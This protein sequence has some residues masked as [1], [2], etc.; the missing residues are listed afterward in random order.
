V[1]RNPQH[2]IRVAA[3][4]PDPHSYEIIVRA[5]VFDE[6]PS[7]VTAAA[8]AA[9]YAVIVPDD[10][11]ASYGRRVSAGLKAANVEVA[12][13]EF[14]AGEASKT[15][16]TWAELTD[17]L[18][19]LRYGRDSCIIAVGGGV[20]GDL[21]GFVAATYMR[22]VPLVQVPTTLL[23]MVDA[24][25]GGKTGVDTQTGKNLIG[26]F[27]AP[28]LV[29][30]DPLVLTTLPPAQ[31]RAGLAETVKHGAVL[32]DEYFAW[33]E[34]NA[35]ALLA[36]EPD[37][38]Q[39]LVARSVELKARVVTEDP[40]EHGIRAALNFGH[41]VGHAL[42]LFSGYALPHGFAVAI[43]MVIEAAA[44][45]AASITAAGTS[46][47]IERLLARLQLPSSTNLVH[48]GSLSDALR[49]D[50]K[51]R[52]GRPRYAL[53]ARI[54]EL[55]RPSA[56]SWTFELPDSIVQRVLEEGRG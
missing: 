46:A 38:L 51:A 20:A 56:E 50:K 10:L 35:D 29:V 43:G 42:E 4:S 8:P 39:H 37:L 25:V 11:T 45:E 32:D 1:N 2:S 13:L 55:A 49:M 33:I 15:R 17:Q 3:T 12:L 19:E 28:R 21:A 7:L 54:G 14:P 40:Y 5:G 18:L 47:R 9:R 23:A 30:A 34:A 52:R 24:S 53:P 31:L 6:L 36:L 48:S 27:H 41:T 22:G 44:G 26:A 16:A